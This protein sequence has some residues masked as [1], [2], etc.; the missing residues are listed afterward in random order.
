MR[1][2]QSIPGVID[3][4][5]EIRRPPLVGMQF[6]HQRPVSP[7]NVGVGRSR[8]QAKDLISLLRSHFAARRSTPLLATPPCRCTLRVLSPSGKPAVKITF[9]QRPALGVEATRHL[10]QLVERKIVEQTARVGTRDHSPRKRS[11]IMIQSH[12]YKFGSYLRF[13]P[14]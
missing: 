2:N 14:A 3:L 4:G 9:K 8:L 6:L 10:N 5:R 13:L 7:T 11:A 12:L 1:A